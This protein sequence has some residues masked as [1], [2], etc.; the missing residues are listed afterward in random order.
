MPDKH[1]VGPPR[2]ELGSNGPKPS[3]IGQANPRT[4]I[5]MD[6]TSSHECY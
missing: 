1:M 6:L 3:S 5:S 2:F 4:R